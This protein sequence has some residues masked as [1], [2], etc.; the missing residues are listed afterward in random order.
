MLALLASCAPKDPGLKDATKGF[1]Y[2]GTAM[3]ANH[4]TGSDI[5]GQNTVIKHFNAI[6]PENCMKMEEIHPANGR[7]EFTIPDMFVEFGLKNKMFIHG[8]TL[9]WHSQCP[10]WFFLNEDGTQVSADELRNRIKEHVTTIVTRYKGKIDSWDVVNECV[11]D[12][13]EMRPSKFYEILGEEFIEIAFQAAA[14]ADPN[15]T[16]YLNDYNMTAPGKRDTYVR[17]I[18]N[19]QAKGI[20]ID[21]MGLQG[22]WGMTS[23]SLEAIQTSID[24]FHNLGV[25]VSITE[26]DM[27]ILPR[28]VS[29]AAVEQNIEFS[30]E[31]DP[32]KGNYP[33]ELLHDWNYRMQQFFEL[34]KV[35]ADKLERV[36]VWGVSD[37]DTW[38]NNWPI[39]GR[40]DYSTLIDRNYQMKVVGHWL[41][42]NYQN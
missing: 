20:K 26:L 25:K 30:Q 6:T 11:L 5:N 19:L 38:H 4:I 41:M 1:F 14:E 9:L 23:P 16:L 22:H 8:H 17:I 36:T 7:Y 42:Q 27:S 32:Y 28:R 10:A 29:T 18:K 39:E 40:I 31:L 34:F 3:N 2:M 33:Q 13:G 15:C 24:A 21:G 35:N 37:N 12:N